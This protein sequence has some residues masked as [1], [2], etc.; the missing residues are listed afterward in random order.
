MLTVFLSSTSKDLDACRKAVHAAIGGMHGYHCVRMEDF[1]SIDQTPDD[2]C[3]AAVGKCNLFVGIA[4]PLYGSVAPAGLSFT[5]REFDAA[6]LGNKPCLVFVTAEDYPLAANLIESDEAR[7]RQSAFR[8]K[9]AEGR[10]VTRF[11]SPDEIPVKVVQA[12]RNWE[13]SAQEALL[14]SQVSSVSYRIAVTNESATVSDDEARAAMAALQTQLRRDFA[15]VWRVDAQLSFVARSADI[16]PGSWRLVVEDD[17]RYP[18]AVCYHTLSSEGLPEVR[19]AARDAVKAGWPWTMAASHDLL[20]MLANPRLNLAIFDSDDARTGRLYIRE[21]C[22]P[23]ASVG[24][25]YEIDG[26]MVSDFVYPAWFERFRAPGS[27]QFDH[28]GHLNAPFQVAPGAYVN[29]CEVTESSGWRPHFAAEAGPGSKSPPKPAPNSARKAGKKA[30][31]RNR[32]KPKKK[33]R[34]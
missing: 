3:R 9:V 15:P 20:E 6:V 26:V 1:G 25:A 10:I 13:A 34:A 23:V 8:A 5:E 22:D 27:A 29:F 11:S 30:A 19:V 4:G 2:F 17:S 21:I 18:G 7:K 33:S 14:A 31:A 12:I 28:R 16:P 32:A 24:L